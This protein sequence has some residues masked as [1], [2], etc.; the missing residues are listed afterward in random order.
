MSVI[1]PTVERGLLVGHL[2][3]ETLRI[4]GQRLH[5]APLAFGV[6]GVERQARLAGSRQAG[7]D[8]QAVA[9]NLERD[10]LE[11]VDACALYGDGRPRGVLGLPVASPGH[12][13]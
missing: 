5:V 2:G 4:A 9:R 1:V 7:D 13:R 8:H 6:D 3:H 11:V 10:V 12:L